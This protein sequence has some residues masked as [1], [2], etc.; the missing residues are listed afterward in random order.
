M[1][2]RVARM[3][4]GWFLP[5][6]LAST[7]AFSTAAPPS[8]A[9]TYTVTAP[10]ATSPTAAPAV[11]PTTPAGKRLSEFLDL[12]RSG[13]LSATDYGA[14]FAAAFRSQVPLEQFNAISEQAL[15]PSV[16]FERVVESSANALVA[17]VSGKAGRITIQLSVDVASRIDGLL[18]TPVPAAT[19]TRW[20]E[21]DSR[22]AKLAPNVRFA[23]TTI[24]AD[25]RCAVVH[26]VA[27]D[28]V[29][30]LGSAFKLYVLAATADAVAAKRLRWDATVTIRDD[31]KSLPSGVLQDRSAG[32]KVRVSEVA[33]KMISISDNT[34]ADL[35][36]QTVGRARVEAAMR[37]TGIADPSRN[38]PF[39]STRELF[40][41]KGSSYPALATNYLAADER[42]RRNLLDTIVAKAKLSTVTPWTR[43]RSIGT[44]EWFGS[45]TDLCRAYAYLL[46]DRDPPSAIAIDDALR[47]NDGGL[48]LPATTWPTVWFKGG[49]EPGVLTLAYLATDAKDRRFVVAVELDDPAAAFDEQRVAVELLAIVKGAFTIMNPG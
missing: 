1:R 3:V 6:G 14:L 7:G 24:G 48:G 19:P 20:T 15:G 29:G 47:I 8:N 4:A 22:L 16:R 46:K 40:L 26:G 10:T 2:R 11:V 38:L 35:L 13:P 34:A 43:P 5:I 25:A 41:L 39:L 21:I 37:A 45:P 30:P 27:P 31:W 33:D 42:G 12:A 28:S 9:T 44:L 18:L 17:I 36:L 32:T 23:A 49:S